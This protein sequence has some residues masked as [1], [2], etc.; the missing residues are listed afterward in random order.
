MTGS[1]GVR[2]RVVQLT[3]AIFEALARQDLVAANA[4]S[5]VPLSAYLA[6][7]ENAGVWRRRHRQVSADPVEADWVTGIVWDEDGRR[8]VGRAGFHGRPSPS[9][10]VEI[11]Y[12]IDPAFR[13]QG[14]A[15]AALAALLDRAAREPSVRTVRL[16]I[17]PD[18]EASLALAHRFGF[19]RVGEQWDDE[20]GLELVH[21]RAA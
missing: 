19:T 5:P 18:N 8:S 9:G 6:G 11:G 16:S 3:G 20:D 13:R 4:L 1:A 2:V 17:G 21:E 15:T 7:P 14:Y 12:A 10:L